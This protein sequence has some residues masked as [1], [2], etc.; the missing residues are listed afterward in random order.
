MTQTVVRNVPLKVLADASACRFCG[1]SLAKP[2]PTA[3][4]SCRQVMAIVCDCGQEWTLA[5]VPDVWPVC[6]GCRKRQFV[7]TTAIATFTVSD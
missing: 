2:E 6:P 5:Q 7:A 1:V 4:P 3:C